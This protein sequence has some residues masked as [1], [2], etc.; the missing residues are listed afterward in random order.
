MELILHLF[1]VAGL[2]YTMMELI[3]NVKIA[4]FLAA[5]ALFLLQIAAIVQ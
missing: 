4:L 1:A 3:L 5:I 2:D